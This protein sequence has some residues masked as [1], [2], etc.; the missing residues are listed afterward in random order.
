MLNYLELINTPKPQHYQKLF[1]WFPYGGC[2]RPVPAAPTQPPQ[3]R[4]PQRRQLFFRVQCLGGGGPVEAAYAPGSWPDQH[5]NRTSYSSTVVHC[6]QSLSISRYVYST[7]SVLSKP[8]SRYLLVTPR[9]DFFVLYVECVYW[10]EPKATCRPYK[11]RPNAYDMYTD[12]EEILSACLCI[13]VIFSP[14]VV[15]ICR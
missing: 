9:V 11:S 14:G 2:L 8:L 1:I 15:N 6:V 7:K 13:C 5:G 12:L 10:T 3:R 4:Y